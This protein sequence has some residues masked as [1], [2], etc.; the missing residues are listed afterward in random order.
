MYKIL[1]YFFF[2]ALKSADSYLNFEIPISVYKI[3]LFSYTQI[4]YFSF[5]DKNPVILPKIS[6]NIN[7]SYTQ[8]VNSVKKDNGSVNCNAKGTDPVAG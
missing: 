3:M 7:T 4:Q 1:L 5:L 6:R 2:R 8:N